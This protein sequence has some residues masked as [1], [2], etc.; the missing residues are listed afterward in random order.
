MDSKY[1][2]LKYKKKYL[3]LKKIIGGGV[4][5][6]GPREFREHQV[7]ENDNGNINRIVNELDIE[8]K[9][10]ICIVPYDN[11]PDTGEIIIPSPRIV[12]LHPCQH[13]YHL[14]CFDNHKNVYI[15]DHRPVTCAFCRV[16]TEGIYELDR[17]RNRW[18]MM[19][20]IV[21]VNND[22]DYYIGDYDDNDYD[23]GYFEYHQNVQLRPGIIPFGKTAVALIGYNQPL[24]PGIFPQTVESLELLDNFNQ[25]INQDVLPQSL[26]VLRFGDDFNRRIR[27]HVLPY[28]LRELYFGNNFNN[29]DIPLERGAIPF[30]VEKLVLG[31]YYNQPILPDVLPNSIT[32]LE[33]PKAYNL[34]L[35]PGSIPNSVET[36]NMGENYHQE[37]PL[38]VIP[39]SVRYIIINDDYEYNLENRFPYVLNISR[40]AI[41]NDN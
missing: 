1:K 12:K 4:N 35:M 34:P 38:D 33:L 25:D 11:D 18:I 5:T 9:C 3:E 27:P 14:H 39:D 22:D 19:E 31:R 7:N 2:Y 29:G 23:D 15:R 40:L 17:G 28:L 13:I 16:E 41:R 32:I 26:E 10:P 6:L 30:G 20:N 36:L 8:D 21:E 37:I 24:I